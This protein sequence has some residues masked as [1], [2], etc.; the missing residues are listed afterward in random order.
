[1]SKN[2]DKTQTDHTAPKTGE[3]VPSASRVSPAEMKRKQESV[4]PVAANSDDAQTHM[5]ANEDQVI[6]NKPPTGALSDMLGKK[7][8]DPTPNDELTPG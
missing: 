7:K 3:V 6:Q 4:P 1:M 8:S 2:Q 5:G